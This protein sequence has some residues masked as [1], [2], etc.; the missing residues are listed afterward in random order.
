MHTTRMTGSLRCSLEARLLELEM[1]ASVLE[2][3]REGE[4][5]LDETALRL[6]LSRE[7]DRIADALANAT[8]IDDAPYDTEAIEIGDMVTVRAMGGGAEE[9]YI[10]VD[11]V[12]WVPGQTGLDVGDVATGRSSARTR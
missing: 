5:S 2:R 8:L 10:L 1:R 3:P 7:R 11:Q 9:Q 6:H 12:G 4:D